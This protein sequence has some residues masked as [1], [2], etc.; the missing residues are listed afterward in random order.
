MKIIT[1]SYRIISIDG[2]YLEGIWFPKYDIFK[3]ISIFGITFHGK[4]I[5][6]EAFLSMKDAEDFLKMI[7][8]NG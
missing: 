4:I 5:N 6:N 3:E 2:D 8:N 1:S 7:G